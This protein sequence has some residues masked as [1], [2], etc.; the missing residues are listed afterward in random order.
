M[1]PDIIVPAQPKPVQAPLAL[2]E[3]GMTN[4]AAQCCGRACP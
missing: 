2:H 3:A 4:I 1:K